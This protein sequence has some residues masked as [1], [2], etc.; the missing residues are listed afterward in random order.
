VVVT[1]PAKAVTKVLVHGYCQNY[2]LPFPGKTL[3]S[4]KLAMT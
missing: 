2:G 4:V 1:L 3:R